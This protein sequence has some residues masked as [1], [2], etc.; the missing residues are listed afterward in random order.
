MPKPR[1]TLT[2]L[3]WLGLGLL[4]LFTLAVLLGY[5]SFGRHPEL[6]IQVPSAAG[7][8]AKAFIIFSRG[9]VI[10]AFLVLVLLLVPRIGL[11]W[12]PAL[13]VAGLLS[14]G[15][16]LLGTYT[17]FPFSGYSYTPLLGYRVLDLV[18]V[19]IPFSWFMMAFPAYVLARRI[20][21][22]TLMPLILGAVILTAWDLTL[23]PAMSDLTKYWIWETSGPYYGM[24]LVN[25]AGWLGTGILIMWAFSLIKADRLA[26]R[27]PA[28]TM[29]I[30]YAT[31]TALSLGMTFIAGYWLPVFLTLAV[32]AGI[33]ILLNK[34]T[35]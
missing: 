2:P 5:G 12:L 33:R 13:A 14:L 1:A 3:D 24:P 6:L 22:G 29:E 25:L 9:H 26:D 23:D 35:I 21:S 19:L 7:F 4:W 30:Y 27:I 10:L 15:M 8:Y 11:R 31:V 18:P 34:N 17:G 28:K 16:E 20:V 32:F